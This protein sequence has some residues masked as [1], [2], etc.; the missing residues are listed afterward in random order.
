MKGFMH[1]IASRI[2]DFLSPRICPVCKAELADDGVHVCSACQSE[3]PYL[4]EKRCPGCGGPGD[5]LFA[6][7]KQCLAVS[8]RP[9]QLA[10]SAF[11][12][13]GIARTSIHR[14]KY[15]HALAMAPFLGHA[16]AEAWKTYG[17][18][19]CADV[20]TSVPLH[21]LRRWRRG[22]N[23]SEEVAKVLSK[24]LGLRYRGD[25]VRRIRRT[26]AQATLD[27]ASRQKNLRGAFVARESVRKLNVLLIDDVFTTG[28]TLTEVTNALLS[29]GA[30]SVAVAT[31]ARDL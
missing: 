18:D 20:V 31:I 10:V 13:E 28:G 2:V 23:Q 16:L 26:A 30:R 24:E 12:F 19:Y 5:G 4:P 3:L 1:G 6:Q 25:L 17:N 29:G 15:R 22:Y 21:W 27:A 9:W 8:D 11:V 14:L 7:C